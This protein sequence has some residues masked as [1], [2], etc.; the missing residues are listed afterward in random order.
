VHRDR[1]I[2]ERV[3][4]DP[5]DVTWLPVSAPIEGRRWMRPQE[6]SLVEISTTGARVIT[7]AHHRIDI[8]SWIELDIEGDCAVAAVK[9]VAA[10]TEPAGIMYGV[11]F[12]MLAAPLRARLENT[13]AAHLANRGLHPGPPPPLAPRHPHAP[14]IIGDEQHSVPT[15]HHPQPVNLR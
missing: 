9:R 7:Q 2:S 12:V 8:G 14:T 1:R 5:I 13:I 11:E 4:I 3:E 10:M 6:G 15:P